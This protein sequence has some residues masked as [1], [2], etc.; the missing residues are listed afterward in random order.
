MGPEIGNSARG[1]PSVP[2]ELNSA[3]RRLPADQ[4]LVSLVGSLSPGQT[5][6][7]LGGPND[8]SLRLFKAIC[9]RT[10]QS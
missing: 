7:V 1:E 3:P 5:W 4:S 8:H 9:G 10:R 6:S 2:N